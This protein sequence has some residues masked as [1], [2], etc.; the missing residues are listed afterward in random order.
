MGDIPQPSKDLKLITYADDCTVMASGP[1]I[2]ELEERNNPY[3]Q[4]LHEWFTANDL[5]L[6][7]GKSS[8]T[9]FTTFSN[10]VSREL[11]IE[12]AGSPVP[13]EKNPKILGVVFD[14][15]HSFKAYTDKLVNKVKK[16]NNVLKALGGTTW[17]KDKEILMST[18]KATGRATLNYAAPVWTASLSESN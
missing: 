2:P 1:T 16:R 12:I 17:G 14:G 5:E 4:T 18:Y 8:A 11:K 6:S 15:L 3:L 10:E 9:I 7:Q 13:T